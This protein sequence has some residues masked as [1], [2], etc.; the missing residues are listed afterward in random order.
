M[1]FYD[2]IRIGASGAADFEVERSLRFVDE[3]QHYLTRTPGSAG[4]RKTWTL[5]VWVKRTTVDANQRILTAY[6][7][8]N[9]NAECN[10]QF[11]S[12]GKLQINN[13]NTS[14]N[15]DTNLKTD[16]LFRD[17]SAWYHIV[18]AT[19]MTQGTAANRVNLYINGEQET[20]FSTESYGTQN[21]DWWFN[22]NSQ[23][24]IGRRHNTTERPFDGYMA[25][26]NFIDGLQLTPASF[27]ETNSDTDQW[28]PKKYTGSYGT[29][30]FYLKFQNLDLFTHFTD[31]SSSQHFITRNGNVIHK[32]DQTKNGA[33]SI[34]F[35]G[36]GDTL[37]VPD[38]TDFT[39][40][41][42]DFTIEAY[43]RRTSQGSDEW[44]FVQSDGTTA[45]TSIGLHIGSSSSGY[46]NR[47]SLRYTEGS[48]GNELQ[49]T[50]TLAANTWYHIAGVRQGNTVRIYVNG[51]QE[52]T[53]SYS[54]TV[55]DSSGPVVIG[56]VNA[57]G[58]AGLTG[59][60]DQLR[61]SNSCRYP[62]GTSF[63]P[64]TTQFTADSNTKLLVQSN[65]TGDLGSDS[66]G[67]GN[68]F[69]PNNFVVGDAVKDTPTNNFA[70][71]R[72][73]G[74]PFE[75]GAGFSEG[76]L[77][78][79]TGSTNSAR[80]L[81][82]QAFSPMLVNSGKWYAEFMQ[83]NSSQNAFI[84][85]GPYQQ[86]SPTQNNTR[87]AYVITSN[88][89]SYVRT[90]GS[91]SISTYGASIAQYDVVGVYID[92]DAGTPIVYFS[93]NGQW[94]DGS[95]NFDESNPTGGITLG[96]SFFTTDTGGND[97]FVTFLC[98]SAGGG[99]NVTIQA[100]FGQ[101]STF[102]GQITAGGNTDANA[103]G[104][105]K[106]P[107]PT[108]AKALCSANLPDPTILLPEKHFNTLV[109]TGNQS[110]NAQTGLDFQPDWVVYKALNPET[111]HGQTLFHDSVRGSTVGK[112][113][114]VH[115]AETPPNEVTNSSYLVSFDSNG[116]TV[117]ND[118]VYNNYQT[119]NQTG[120][121]YQALCWNGGNSD[122]ATYRVVV[123]S[124]SGNKYRFR[125]SANTATF[126]QSAVTLDLAEGGTYT[127][128]Q[129]DS[130]MSSHPMKLSTTANGTHGGGSSYNTGVTYELD[131]ST[132]TESAFVSGFSSATS[133][134]L[135]I[136]VAASAPTLYYYCHYHS[137]MGG[138]ANTNSTAGSSNFDGSIQT[139]VKANTTAGFS[140][141]TYTGTG[142]AGATIGHG[143]GVKPDAILIKRRDA[144]DNWMVY[145]NQANAGV[146]PED[147]YGELNSTSVN[148]NST[149]MLND[150]APT[151]T[152][153]TLGG[154]NSVNGS[155][156]TYVSY[157]F[158]EVDGYSKFNL[159]FGN[160]Q[161]N[162][163]M[164]YTG[165]R[166]AWLMV[167]Q[168]G[169]DNWYMV[170]NK[171]DPFNVMDHRLFADTASAEGGV[172][173]EH[174][175]FLSNGFKWR[176]PKTPFNNTFNYL[177]FCFA[178]AP[179]KNSRAR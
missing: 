95:G 173:Q 70:G 126:A 127:F 66:S 138:Q 116:I 25:E 83:K 134:K 19:D 54:G 177:Y 79:V 104:D 97:G 163:T 84:G 33:T 91:E 135:I 121:L 141:V 101:D 143:L 117:G 175:D 161:Y 75:S 124:D 145:H 32:S 1:S 149:I 98:S 132:V 86:L 31:T 167:K 8:S 106:Y 153:I 29:N 44:F 172:G 78:L 169:N 18:V 89:Q 69:T 10:I 87:Y 108:G 62:D 53:A 50:T 5:S 85:V 14:S 28:I 156:A 11:Q 22:N 71:L 171:R 159:Y 165:F 72:M 40:G 88:G 26:F 57:A 41:S 164:V 155:S 39:V 12:D 130:T 114:R 51:T 49:G 16:R 56:A 105:F 160:F 136:T 115:N 168:F 150:T 68:N 157:V 76:N 158:S 36:S 154:D 129:S 52:A 100:N 63:T 46:A 35:D 38:S 34:Y 58:S 15:T 42:N 4:N 178:E 144:A 152:S 113:I 107:V 125:N 48:T 81:N 6:D 111:G 45:N 162:G 118:G 27:G 123:V 119:Y 122:G 170:D 179:F 131:G 176:R 47:P 67:N 80:N 110:T 20:S 174:V 102:S 64:P 82:R 93:K 137:G 65:V 13:N 60:L 140:I 30:G 7:G 142:S 3:D 9:V 109:F 23:Q 21:V 37:T 61:W 147:Y 148:I 43:V 128:D 17:P 90:A 139:T 133:R 96:D 120:R 55:N 2:A 112:G 77:E 92:M 146:D 94:A 151:S 74:T 166:P 24:T 73:M 103:L 59:Y 99:T